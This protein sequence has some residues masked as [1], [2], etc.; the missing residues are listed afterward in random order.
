[1]GELSRLERTVAALR[2]FYGLL[3]WPPSDAFG[4]FVWE[5][6]SFQTTAQ[7]R[8]LAF[9]ALKRHRAL[10]PDAMAKVAPKS[11]EDSVRLAGPYFDQRLRALRAA[12]AV[13]QRHP[14]LASRINGPEPAARE[15]VALLPQVGDGA[16]DRMLLFAGTHAAFP[17]DAETRRV[18]GRLEL[19]VDPSGDAELCRYATIYVSHHARST[20]TDADPHCAVCPL[21]DDCPV[22]RSR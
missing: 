20:C 10:T 11:V 15:A 21:R 14:D 7:K 13:F 16:G 8:D 5:T 4:F 12:I 18:L 22:G 9:A 2:Q 19:D 1:M 17:A 3:P 6:L